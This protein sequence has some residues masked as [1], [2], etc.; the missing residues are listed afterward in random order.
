MNKIREWFYGKTTAEVRN[1]LGCLVALV[2]GLLLNVMGVAV[3]V[4]RE[5]R[6]AR[7]GCFG[8]EWDDV[9]RYVTW[10]LV[11]CAF[12]IGVILYICSL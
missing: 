7:E 6:Q 12:N 8:V 9:C 1:A 3:M 11:G 4:V 5:L 10:G 2:L